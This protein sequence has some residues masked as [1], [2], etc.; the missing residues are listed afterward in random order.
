MRERTTPAP[1]QGLVGLGYAEVVD[2]LGKFKR[3]QVEN[4]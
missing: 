1:N 2:L 3:D 4:L